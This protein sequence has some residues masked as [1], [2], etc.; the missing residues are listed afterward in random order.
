MKN[1]QDF[2]VKAGVKSTRACWQGN[3]PYR[4][5]SSQRAFTLA[6]M[7][8]VLFIIGILTVFSI[9][10]LK[11]GED[12]YGPLYYRAFEALKI[13]NY[14]VFTDLYPKSPRKYP[15]VINDNDTDENYAIGS[16]DQIREWL[17]GKTATNTDPG[18][19]GHPGGICQRLLEYINVSEGQV[20]CGAIPID[21]NGDDSQFDGNLN[22]D[23]HLAFKGSNSQRFYFGKKP[24]DITIHGEKVKDRHGNEVDAKL[25]WFIVYVDLNGERGPNSTAVT[26]SGKT[27]KSPDIVAFAL[28]DQGQIAPIGL[29]RVERKFLTAKVGY[30]HTYCTSEYQMT[31]HCTSPEDERIEKR[32]SNT[33]TYDE[34]VR[35][36][37]GVTKTYQEADTID[38]TKE[39]GVLNSI[40]TQYTTKFMPTLPVAGVD[41]HDSNKKSDATDG[42]PG[43]CVEG[44]PLENPCKVLIEKYHK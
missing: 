44:K 17:S 29:P 34:A 42:L 21:P 43:D 9:L 3:E 16:E 19:A 8:M 32:F 36:A 5:G 12:E 15:T 4:A 38:F 31:Y 6:E 13:A 11:R 27:A 39:P 26:G 24:A 20:N 2:T 35:R 22:A 28:T 7:L 30:P 41:I 25:G 33:M 23:G 10:T 37:W 18:T 1:K 14:N 40:R